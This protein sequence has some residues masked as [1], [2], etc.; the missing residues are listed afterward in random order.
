MRSN[1][2]KITRDEAR[3]N[4]MQAIKDDNKE[5]YA[6]AM[7]DMMQCIEDEIVQKHDTQL[8]DIR[9]AADRQVLAARG[10][11]QLT[12][13]ESS[14]TRNWPTPCAAKTPSRRLWIP[15]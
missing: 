9:D 8:A 3:L 1:D 7:N 13:E 6:K 2:L 15:T 14:I 5:A 12:S 10:V 11:R 4:L